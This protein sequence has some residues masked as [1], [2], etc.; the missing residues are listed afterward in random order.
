MSTLFLTSGGLR[1]KPVA[2]EFLKLIP[3]KPSEIR[4]AHIITASK[5]ARHLTYLEEDKEAFK[6][7]G[8]PY[9]DIDIEGKTEEELRELLKDFDVIYVQGGDPYYLLK[10]IK[11]SGFDTVVK[12]LIVSGKLYVGASAGSYVAC[13]TLESTVWKKPHRARHDLRDDEP[14]MHLIPFLLLVHYEEQHKDIVKDGISYA[15]YPVRILT[16]NQAFIVRDGEVVLAGSGPE[17]HL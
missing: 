16:N 14:A 15:K 3:K 17:V 7:L 9:K 1:F 8:I 13:P 5:M 10:H 11:L 4:M 2:D 6:T 12:E